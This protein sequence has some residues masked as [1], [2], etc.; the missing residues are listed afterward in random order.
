[1]GWPRSPQRT[2]RS[3]RSACGLGSLDCRK[4]S[5]PIRDR[6][7]RKFLVPCLVQQVFAARPGNHSE[8]PH[9]N[10]FRRL[11]RTSLPENIWARHRILGDV[12]QGS[13]RIL[14]TRQLHLRPVFAFRASSIHWNSAIPRHG[15]LSKRE[16]LERATSAGLPG[17]NWGLHLLRSLPEFLKI[18]HPASNESMARCG[19]LQNVLV[20]LDA[21]HVARTP[22]FVPACTMRKHR[23]PIHLRPSISKSLLRN[24][25]L[26]QGVLSPSPPERN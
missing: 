24:S 26:F 22:A 19:H 11:P 10:S 12:R 1:M 17:P 6:L 4:R 20:P 5:F 25:L 23:A 8:A 16:G 21:R 18:V 2:S 9:G 15:V 14:S 7:L 13:L 3:R